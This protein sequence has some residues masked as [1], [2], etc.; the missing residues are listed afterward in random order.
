MAAKEA[1]REKAA[2]RLIL[3]EDARLKKLREPLEPVTQMKQRMCERMNGR[4][5]RGKM[6]AVPKSLEHL[7]PVTSTPSYHKFIY[8]NTK[9]G[10]KLDDA[11]ASET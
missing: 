11:P 5:G 9:T 10:Q 2:R 7:L 6:N 1:K 3:E 4:N 8:V